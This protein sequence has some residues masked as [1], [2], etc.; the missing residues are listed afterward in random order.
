MQ[1]LY[2]TDEGVQ[3][4][5]EERLFAAVIGL[6]LRDACMKPIKVNNRMEMQ[7]EAQSAHKFIWS[8][9]IES[10]LHWLDIDAGQFRSRIT[11]I[12]QNTDNFKVGGF[13]AEERRA[14]RFNKTLWE[15]LWSTTQ[16]DA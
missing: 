8:D 12:M 4:T 15:D 16:K 13:S 6:A 11:A 7:S 2:T 9:A 14:F 1:N 3:S 10:Y 5:P